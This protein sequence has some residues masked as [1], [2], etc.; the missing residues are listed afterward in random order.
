MSQPL[1]ADN[2]YGKL[3]ADEVRK[4]VQGMHAAIGSL[5][6]SLGSLN[7]TWDSIT[8]KPSVF[9]PDSHTHVRAD[10][11]DF[12]HTHV[13]S[14]ITDFAHTHG[15]ADITNLSSYTGLDARYYTETE[16]NSLLGG[17]LPTSGGSMT[18]LLTLYPA[19]STA[20]MAIRFNEGYSLY[21]DN[22]GAGTDLSRVWL[23]GPDGGEL[24]LGPRSGAA[25]FD[26]MRLRSRN[27][28]VEGAMTV[29]ADVTTQLTVR[30]SST[31]NRL[32]MLSSSAS[33]EGY[34][35]NALSAGTVDGSIIIDGA[36]DRLV[37]RPGD[38]DGT[39]HTV[40]H[41]GSVGDV[42]GAQVY[43]FPDGTARYM[44]VAEWYHTGTYSHFLGEF[45]HVNRYG[46]FTYNIETAVGASTTSGFFATINQGNTYNDERGPPGRIRILHQYLASSTKV[47]LWVYGAGWSGN[48]NARL[49]RSRFHGGVTSFAWGSNTVSTTAPSGVSG[50][51]TSTGN[52]DV[53]GR[54][55]VNGTLHVASMVEHTDDTNTYMQFHAADQWRVV[56]GGVERLEVNNS[57]VW[58][59]GT[60]RIPV[61]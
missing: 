49:M 19:A 25:W 61:K 39:R 1:F 12:A 58:V 54:L 26:N 8:G 41:T 36:N 18:G 47:E 51:N 60:L 44:K 57:W 14:D 20:S 32:E 38:T 27:V 15:T 46:T 23:D 33:N 55:V 16:V 21:V 24:V 6:D 31:G 4:E 59:P 48:N 10:I 9:P 28:S 50:T 3:P 40:I 34:I 30:R 52:F 29:L 13:K 5:A 2:W 35:R 43:N 42:I 17:Y 45:E 22:T 7:L 56:T 11:S 37:W 53:Q